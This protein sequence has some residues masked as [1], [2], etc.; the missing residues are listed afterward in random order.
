MGQNLQVASYGEMIDTDLISKIKD[1]A[2]GQN[3]YSFAP[4]SC[5]IEFKPKDKK[6]KIEYRDCIIDYTRCTNQNCIKKLV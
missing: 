6:T 4:Y 2:L 5:F 3:E 1:R